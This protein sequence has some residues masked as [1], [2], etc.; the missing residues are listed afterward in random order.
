MYQGLE[1]RKLTIIQFHTHYSIGVGINDFQIGKQVA[2]LFDGSEKI[3]RDIQI[4]KMS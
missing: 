1:N 4:V 3:E 2:Q